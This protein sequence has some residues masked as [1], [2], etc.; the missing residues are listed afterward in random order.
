MEGVESIGPI[1]DYL[2]VSVW[3]YGSWVFINFGMDNIYN[4]DFGD[5]NASP[6]GGL[7]NISCGD[8][9]IK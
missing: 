3:A 2:I 4:R 7:R 6:I 5:T 1:L 8:G 9:L